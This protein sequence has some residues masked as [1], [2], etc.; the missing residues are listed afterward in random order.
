M[1]VYNGPKKDDV[2]HVQPLENYKFLDF[3]MQLKFLKSN[4]PT[5]LCTAYN[6]ITQQFL[7]Y[8]EVGGV[9]VR[10]MFKLDKN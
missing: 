4:A 10:T 1:G 2:I 5:S 9:G 3:F 6:G 7:F 8:R